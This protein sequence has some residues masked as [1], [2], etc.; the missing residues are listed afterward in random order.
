M[1]IYV[2]ESVITLD[3]GHIMD[4]KGIDK[5][6]ELLINAIKHIIVKPNGQGFRF[7]NDNSNNVTVDSY[8]L[9]HCQKS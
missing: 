6:S 3:R 4:N 7:F 8:N 5:L 9:Q 1:S 2:R